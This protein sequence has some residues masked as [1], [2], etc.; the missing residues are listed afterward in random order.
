MLKWR[1]WQPQRSQKPPSLETWGFKSPFEHRGRSSPRRSLPRKG[2]KL[3][4][5][6]CR[7]EVVQVTTPAKTGNFGFDPHPALG[8]AI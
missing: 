6:V 1:N 7:E 5:E 4:N 2:F 8:K 3:S